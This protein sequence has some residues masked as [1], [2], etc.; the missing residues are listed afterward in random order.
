MLDI[1]TQNA[2]APREKHLNKPSIVSIE[3]KRKEFK[4][5]K[6]NKQQQAHYK[7]KAIE[8]NRRIVAG[9]KADGCAACGY[10][11]CA[12]ALHF[13][14][15]DPNEKEMTIARLRSHA[16][17]RLIEEIEKCIVL[18]ANCHHELHDRLD[19]K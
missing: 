6:R 9:Y 17:E 4:K 16:V 14:H 15:L 18:C 13:H 1:M 11:K 3:L 12:K 19:K 5:R 10:N 8:R 7:K 2:H